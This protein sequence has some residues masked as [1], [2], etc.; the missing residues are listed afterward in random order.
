LGNMIG[1]RGQIIG[2][3]G[4]LIQERMCTMMALGGEIACAG[5]AVDADVGRLAHAGI[6][7]DGFT[8]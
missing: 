5:K 8:E 6:S 3:P 2:C 4:N 1:E 7:A